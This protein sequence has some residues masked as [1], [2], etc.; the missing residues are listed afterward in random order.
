MLW[1]VSYLPNNQDGAFEQGYQGRSRILAWFNVMSLTA[2]GHYVRVMVR[3]DGSIGFR[4]YAFYEPFT[5][6]G[7][8]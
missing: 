3:P 7:P 4:N 8:L 2:R 5:L 1:D 6:A